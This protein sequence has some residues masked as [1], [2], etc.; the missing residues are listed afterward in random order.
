MEHKPLLMGYWQD[1]FYYR[2]FSKGSPA[3]MNLLDIPEEY[4]AIA[5]SNGI[6]HRSL[7]SYV[8]VGMTGIE[9]KEQVQQL[10]SQGRQLFFNFGK[11]EQRW[12]GCSPERL[13]EDLFFLVHNYEIKGICIDLEKEI[14]DE[15]GNRFDIP[16]ALKYLKDCYKRRNYNFSIC[17]VYHYS[18]LRNESPPYLAE[19]EGYYDLI[20]AKLYHQDHLVENTIWFDDFEDSMGITGGEPKEDFLYYLMDSLVNGTRGFAKIPHDK[21]ILGLPA[22]QDT[23]VVGHVSDPSAVLNTME[24]LKQ[25]GTP[26]RGLSAYSINWDAGK[27]KDG[28]PYSY[29]FIKRY[30][31]ILKP[32]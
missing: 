1:S 21:L 2:P 13:G 25:N 14:F 28:Q 5:V 10:I 6:Q 11:L 20:C 12:A 16:A 9:F 15:N 17:L 7:D 31:D 24:R 32:T 3:D 30:K 4:N 23:T 22:N 18:D 26:I 27:A 19:M 8:P 29:E